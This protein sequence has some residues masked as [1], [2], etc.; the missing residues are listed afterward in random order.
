MANSFSAWPEAACRRS[1]GEE[2]Q[3][4]TACS[5]PGVWLS[6]K[7]HQEGRG[8]RATACSSPL[9]ISFPTALLAHSWLLFCLIS[10]VM[11]F[12]RRAAAIHCYDHTFEISER[13]SRKKEVGL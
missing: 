12:L 4:S 10:P 3:H 1:A 13:S 2:N 6:G 7:H 5:R 11:Y 9:F 8:H